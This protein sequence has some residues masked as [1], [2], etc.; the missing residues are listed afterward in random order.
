[1]MWRPTRRLRTEASPRCGTTLGGQ[2]NR[3]R[4]FFKNTPMT[5]TA[6][7][8][9]TSGAV[10]SF[11]I[12]LLTTNAL[13]RKR[14]SPSALLPKTRLAVLLTHALRYDS[15]VIVYVPRPSALPCPSELP[16]IG[17]HSAPRI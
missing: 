3:K 10:A 14:L 6:L 7:A 5:Q 8:N 9:Q 1:M 2:S 15:Q 4:S 13:L 17:G 11:C 16:F 12:F